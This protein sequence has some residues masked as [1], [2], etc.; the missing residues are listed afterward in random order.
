MLPVPPGCEI[1]QSESQ[2]FYT[3][4]PDGTLPNDGWALFSG[5]S[6][7]A[8][9]IAGAA[10]L[11][12]SAKPGLTPAQVTEALKATAVD[13]RMGHCHPRFN[14]PAQIDHDLATGHGIIDASAAVQYALD[15]F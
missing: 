8:P 6:A 10:A 3:D 9:Q 5:T 1:D 11:I 12:L 14:F 13:V 15:S 2:P 4:P 7:A